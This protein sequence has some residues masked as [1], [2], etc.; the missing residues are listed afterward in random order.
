MGSTERS[1]V[2]RALKGA[3]RL[4]AWA[5]ARGV[6]WWESGEATSKTLLPTLSWKE[7]RGSAGSSPSGAM[8]AALRLKMLREPGDLVGLDWAGEE[9]SVVEEEMLDGALRLI[10]EVEADGV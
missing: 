7:A 6:D 9:T 3:P 4:G 10:R 8:E 2:W 5:D 1:V